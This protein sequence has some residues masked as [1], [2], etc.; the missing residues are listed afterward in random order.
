MLISRSADKLATVAD[1]ATIIR[2]KAK[3]YVVNLVNVSWVKEKMRQI[4]FDFGNIDILAS[5]T[6]MV[7]TATLS[8]KPLSGWQ[9]VIDLNLT[10]AFGCIQRILLSMR[11]KNRG[12]IVNVASIHSQQALAN[13]AAY[14]VNFSDA[15]LLPKQA[16]VDK[17]TLMLSPGVV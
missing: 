6:G 8:Q 4:V 16:V 5:N 3:N 15:A 2:V 11:Q 7:Y 14:S 1:T 9:Q 12:K 17:L 10:R 13:W